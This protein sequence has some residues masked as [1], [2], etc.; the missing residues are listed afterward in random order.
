VRGLQGAAGVTRSAWALLLA[1]STVVA[2]AAQAAE[3]LPVIVTYEMQKEHEAARAVQR[4]PRSFWVHQIMARIESKRMT[5]TRDLN[6]PV[7]VQ[8][9][10]TVARDG[11]LVSSAIPRSSG[12]DEADTIALAMVR[13]A[14]PFPAMPA[15]MSDA[16]VSFTLPVRFR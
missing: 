14:E 5:P 7:T 10:F 1:A 12:V 11:R 9:A 6:A 4:D 15:A 13:G 16:D 2:T 8:V 3:T